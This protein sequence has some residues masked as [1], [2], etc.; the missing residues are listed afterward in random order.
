MASKEAYTY[1]PIHEKT[2]RPQNSEGIIIP[3]FLAELLFHFKEIRGVLEKKEFKVKTLWIS[4]K[5]TPLSENGI[6][7]SVV[8][9]FKTYCELHVTPSTLRQ[10]CP[11]IMFE[12]NIT[13]PG[14]GEEGTALDM[15]FMLDTS[16]NMLN[17]NYNRGTAT[18][19]ML[20]L[21][22][23]V[24]EE[25]FE[26]EDS[27]KAKKDLSESLPTKRKYSK[28]TSDDEDSDESSEEEEES[29]EGSSSEEDGGKEEGETSSS[30][31]ED[32]TE[33]ISQ[34]MEEDEPSSNSPVKILSHRLR[35]NSTLFFEVKWENGKR[36]E[37]RLAAFCNHQFVLAEYMAKIRKL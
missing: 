26:T 12:Q 25:I 33:D 5:G 30:E 4:K 3:N 20:A 11:T 9:I 36:T 1:A 18:R 22:K 10:I 37:E 16:V 7:E 8:K 27:R 13:V 23:T 21:Q 6:R 2:H 32:D 28:K 31:D 17:S 15:G 34:D 29:S 24:I 14:R 19:R 35:K